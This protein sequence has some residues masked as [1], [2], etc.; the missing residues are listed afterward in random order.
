MLRNLPLQKLERKNVLFF[1]FL[2]LIFNIIYVDN[3]SLRN[4]FY[5]LKFTC[6]L[7]QTRLSCAQA[8]KLITN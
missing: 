4:T 1:T 5:I 2:I 8:Y 7:S 6:R 3:L